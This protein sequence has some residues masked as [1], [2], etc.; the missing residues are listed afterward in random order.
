MTRG[1][2]LISI[3]VQPIIHSLTAGDGP[4]SLWILNSDLTLAEFEAYLETNG[5]LFPDDTTSS[6]RASRGKKIRYLGII[7]PV[8]NGTVAVPTELIKNQAMAGLRW[9]EAGEGAGLSLVLYN[10][11]KA[12]TT[13]SSFISKSQHFVRWT[14]GG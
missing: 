4:F 10:L 12:L 1:G 3:S 14:P 2:T 7:A 5:P 11:G 8:G 6:E 13:G 9:S